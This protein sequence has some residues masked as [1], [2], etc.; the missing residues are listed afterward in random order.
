[1]ANYNDVKNELACIMRCNEDELEQYD[2]I[3]S[4]AIECISFKLCDEEKLGE[5]SVIHLCAARAYLEIMLSSTD[6][7]VTSFKA[8][9]ISFTRNTSTLENARELYSMALDACSPLLKSGGS[10]AFK[11]V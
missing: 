5:G 1:M 3:I 7:D 4:S 11:V 8:G 6:E 10:F 2:S 9:D